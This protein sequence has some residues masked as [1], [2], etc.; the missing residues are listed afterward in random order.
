MNHA[1]HPRGLWSFDELSSS[2]ARTLLST[3]RAFKK[4]KAHATPLKGKHVAVLCEHARSGAADVYTAAARGLGAQVTRIRP[5][6]SGLTGPGD[7]HDTARVMGRLYDAI[8]CDGMDQ[9]FMLELARTA[10]VPVSNVLMP[11]YHPTRLLA[12][13]MT[14]QEIATGP[15]GALTV[16]VLG[17]AQAPW[18]VAW[19]R[20]AAVT[21]VSVRSGEPRELAEQAEQAQKSGQAAPGIAFVSDPGGERCTDGQPAL[22]A[23]GRDDAGGVSL[24]RRQ[25]T[26][27]R[28]VVQALLA[29]T[30]N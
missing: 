9:A 10:A 14:M 15:I 8:E 11:G 21:G 23:V 2:D 29:H 16:C 4:D 25:V 1:L 20:M 26:N 5:S 17:D 7:M 30:I 28:F 12:D 27:H 13:L 3:A 22:M 18:S 6:A 19:R 24:A